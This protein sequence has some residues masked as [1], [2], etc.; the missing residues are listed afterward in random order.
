MS[1]SARFV[2]CGTQHFNVIVLAASGLRHRDMH[3][4]LDMECALSACANIHVRT[5]AMSCLERP[6]KTPSTESIELRLGS[7]RFRLEPHG[8]TVNAI[9]RFVTAILLTSNMHLLQMD[10]HRVLY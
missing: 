5:R 10:M 6:Y 3:S 7:T 4:I 9:G 1:E 2:S 8:G